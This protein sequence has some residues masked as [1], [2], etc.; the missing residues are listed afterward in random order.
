MQVWPSVRPRKSCTGTARPLWSYYRRYW[1]AH[2]AGVTAW[3]HP[4]KEGSPTISLR[5][6]F[7]WF[8]VGTLLFDWL[9][10]KLVG[11]PLENI[12]GRQNF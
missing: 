1:I 12:D 2:S 9:H 5:N 7:P 10:Y 4:E 8:V 11:N 3:V 6:D